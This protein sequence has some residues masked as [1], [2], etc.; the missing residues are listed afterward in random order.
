MRKIFGIQIYLAYKVQW[1]DTRIGQEAGRLT[2]GSGII[3][4][5]SAS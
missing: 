3:V 5:G 1:Q 4:C 2:V